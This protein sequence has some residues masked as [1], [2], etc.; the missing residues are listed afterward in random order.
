[1][2]VIESKIDTSTKE[3]K[4]NFTNYQKLVDNLKKEISIAKRGG[5]EEKIKLHKSKISYIR[6]SAPAGRSPGQK[7]PCCAR[8]PLKIGYPG[9]SA[10]FGFKLPGVSFSVFYLLVPK[11]SFSR[12]SGVSSYTRHSAI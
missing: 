8:M 11:P 12:F 3:Y 10:G 7:A 6:D 1:M 4:E 5:G 9:R 2:D